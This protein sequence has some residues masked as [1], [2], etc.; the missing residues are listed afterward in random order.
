MWWPSAPRA[1]D[2]QAS[3]RAAELPSPATTRMHG[4]GMVET[5]PRSR[6]DSSWQAR[7]LSRESRRACL[8]ASSRLGQP[9]SPRTPMPGA[10]TRIL[11]KF[12]WPGVVHAVSDQKAVLATRWSGAYTSR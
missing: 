9:A 11:R 7:R 5:A 3:Q 4:W 12:F 8:R 10:M 1:H 6:A 2:D